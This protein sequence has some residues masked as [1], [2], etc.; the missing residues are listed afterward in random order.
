MTMNGSSATAQST[1]LPG[2]PDFPAVPGARHALILL[3]LI[4]LFNYIDRQVLAAVEPEIAKSFFPEATGP[5]PNEGTLMGLLSTAFLITYMLTAPIFGWLANRM[6]RWLL[7]GLGVV[8]W[9]LASGGSGLAGA[10][11]GMLLTCAV[12]SVSERP[13]MAR[14]LRTSSRIST[15]SRNADKCYRGSTPPSR[16]VVPSATSS[17]IALSGTSPTTRTAGVSPS[18]SSCLPESCSESGASSCASRARP[19]GPDRYAQ[20]P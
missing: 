3:V 8:I 10:Y 15:R 20:T 4:N 17:L 19:C 7:I 18:T 11:V 13:F 6:S 12:S 9:S 2:E 14:S 1:P 5:H 16:S